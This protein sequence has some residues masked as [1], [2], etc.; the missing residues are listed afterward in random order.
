M[1]SRDR[2]LCAARR[3]QPDRQA[4]S[5]RCTPEAWESLAEYL[6]VGN[7]NDVL[8]A[9]DID[10]RWLSLPFIG[11]EDRTSGPLGS[12]GVDYWGCRTRK[13]E[14]EFN[15]YYEFDYHPLE[16]AESVREIEDHDWPSLEWWDYDAIPAQIESINRSGERAIMFFAG[17]T[18]ETPWYMRGFERFVMDL[19]DAPEMVD[20]ICSRVREYYFQRAERVIEAAG[21][22][23]DIIGS[24]GDI[25]SQRAMLINPAIWRRRIKPHTAGLITPFKERGLVTFYHSCGSLVPVIG[26]DSTSDPTAMQRSQNWLIS[27]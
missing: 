15:T 24:G 16:S 20:A 25:G 23:I 17:G 2:V 5:L 1:T 4:T 3:E 10:L 21:G 8:N 9:L 11:P 18:F 13:V 22:R 12:E 6:D 14:N 26:R 27:P 7:Q 19:Y